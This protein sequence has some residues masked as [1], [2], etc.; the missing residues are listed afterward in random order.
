MSALGLVPAEGREKQMIDEGLARVSV[1]T[2]GGVTRVD[3]DISEA[4]DNAEHLRRVALAIFTAAVALETAQAEWW[5]SPHG[6]PGYGWGR[7]GVRGRWVSARWP[8]ST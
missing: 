4:T 5:S 2:R 6:A 1:F 8:V 7:R 3:L